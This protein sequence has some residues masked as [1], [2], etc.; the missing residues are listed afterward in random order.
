M[1]HFWLAPPQSGPGQTYTVNATA[2]HVGH[3]WVCLRRPTWQD[4]RLALLKKRK[5]RHAGPKQITVRSTANTCW[6]ARPLALLLIMLVLSM[7]AIELVIALF[8]RR[9]MAS[10]SWRP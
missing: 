9:V 3:V 6:L 5:K 8:V 7:A 4:S 2:L 1:E 10:S